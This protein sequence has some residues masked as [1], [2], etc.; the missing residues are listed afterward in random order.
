MSLI[1]GMNEELNRD[2]ELLQQY[3]QIGGLFA[4]TILKAKIKEA[5]DSIASGNVVRM[6]IAYKTLKNSK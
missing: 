4:F 3:Q 1:A 2:R 5:E 6:L